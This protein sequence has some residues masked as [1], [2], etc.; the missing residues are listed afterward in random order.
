MVNG[1][2][3]SYNYYIA[4]LIRQALLKDLEHKRKF[5]FHRSF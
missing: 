2:M 4:Y 5:R 3:F 1:G